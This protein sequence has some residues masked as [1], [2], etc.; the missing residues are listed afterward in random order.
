VWQ[1]RRSYN[2]EA[3]TMNAPALPLSSKRVDIFRPELL[4]GTPLACQAMIRIPTPSERDSVAARM[5]ELGLRAVTPETLRATQI[6]ELYKVEWLA[7]LDLVPRELAAKWERINKDLLSSDEFVDAE[8]AWND[9]VA[10][11]LAQKLDDFWLRVAA[12][13]GAIELWLEQEAERLTD[14]AHG[15]PPRDGMPRPVQTIMPRLRA[16]IRLLTDFQTDNCPNY[17]RLLSQNIRFS[18]ENDI[19]IFRM[20]LLAIEG[21]DWPAEAPRLEFKDGL[22]TLESCDNVREYI[23]DPAWKEIVRRCDKPYR[24]TETE[25]KNFGL[26]PERLSDPTGSPSPSDE[27]ETRDGKWTDSTITPAP[28][29]GSATTI[30][31]SS[32]TPSASEASTAGGKGGPT[33]EAG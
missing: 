11:M 4:E 6:S 26:Q 19:L 3:I 9:E 7:H 23:G 5:F 33:A 22:V 16:E 32:D 21:D 30:A 24:L 31:S 13:D 12:E 18:Q 17:A 15:A 20:H 27:S 28:A 1:T 14:E 29:G 8:A 2:P 25:R 10:D